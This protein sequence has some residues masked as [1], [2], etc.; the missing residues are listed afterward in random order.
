MGLEEKGG[1]LA[2]RWSEASC[3]VYLWI[4]VFHRGCGRQI[5]LCSKLL[6]F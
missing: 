3:Q 2:V 4:P 5:L 6:G 1:W